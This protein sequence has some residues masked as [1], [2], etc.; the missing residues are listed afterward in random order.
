[1]KNFEE[2]PS[3]EELGRMA[4]HL[5]S[6]QQK[7]FKDSMIAKAAAIIKRNK[8]CITLNLEALYEK[9]KE[10]LK[11]IF[12]YASEGIVGCLFRLLGMGF[13][14]LACLSGE[15]VI[16][17]WTL[18]TFRLADSRPI[19]SRSQSLRSVSRV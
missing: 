12:G 16:W 2:V 10:I 1:M 17:V 3:G 19:L 6:D 5:P 11:Q 7:S 18:E 14:L 9:E 4:Y 13:L 15:F 8:A